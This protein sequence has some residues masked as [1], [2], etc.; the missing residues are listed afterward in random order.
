MNTISPWAATVQTDLVKSDVLLEKKVSDYVFQFCNTG[1]SVWVTAQWPDGGKVAFRTAFGL[2]SNFEVNNLLDDENVVVLQLSNKI[3]KYEVRLQFPEADKTI[4][5]YTTTF[6]PNFPILIPFWPRDIIPITT[7]GQIQNTSGKI[8]VSQEGTRSGLLFASFTKPKTGSFLYFQNLTALSQYGE[9][10]ETSLGNTVG[11]NWPEIGFQL[12]VAEHPLPEKKFVVSD[13]YV[14]LTAAIPSDEIEISKSFLEHLSQIYAVMPK[15]ETNY[16]DWQHIS[17]SALNDITNNK[18]CWSYASS[19]PYLNAYLSDYET[20]PE[21]MVQLS[22]L[23]AV[24]E[25]AKWTG[26]KYTVTKDIKNGLQAFYDPELQ[27]IS[28]WLPSQRDKLDESEEQKSPM[29]MDSWYLHHPLMNLSKLALDG[30]NDAK[31]LLMDSL[32]YAVKVAHHFNYQWPVFYKMDTLETIKAETEPGKGGEK[33]VAGGYANLMCNVWKLTGEK[34]YLSE[35]KKAAEKLR[36]NGLDIFYQANNTAFSALAMLRLYIETNDEKY[37]ET[38][39]LC[40]AGI[41]RNVQLWECDYGYSKNFNNFFGI[42]PLSD[43][44]YKAAYEEMEVYAAINDYIT[45]ASAVKAPILPALH[46]LLPELVRYSV[47]RLPAYYPTMLPAEVLT[48]EVKTG[49]ID[50]TLWIPLEDLYDG[51]EKPGQVGQEVYGAGVGFGVVPR[52]YH[53][54]KG[55]RFVVYCDYPIQN[56]KSNNYKSVFFK[57]LGNAGLECKMQIISEIK[58][59]HADFIISVESEKK[60]TVLKALKST[61]KTMEFAIPGNTTIKIKWK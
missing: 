53:K 49:E 44:P 59:K 31:K 45:K 36:E 27:T 15:P 12:P 30:D 54:V 34:Q 10:T 38:S 7:N 39:Y 11:G 60:E 2:N 48:A 1:D 6:Q 55:E 42:F 22:V 58:L 32:P 26:K 61:D 13:A 33:D 43:A 41:M 25:Y 17:E 5:H 52:Q 35:A 56:F 50:P 19:H 14:N 47:N 57:T 40:L 3:G 29:V 23:H 16:N 4:F 51:W 46:V 20:P 21:I 8:H 24:T 28:R 37:L 9:A 18:G